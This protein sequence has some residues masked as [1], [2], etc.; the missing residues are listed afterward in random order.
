[1]L[2]SHSIQLSKNSGEKII[3]KTHG[4]TGDRYKWLLQAKYTQLRNLIYCQLK[5]DLNQEGKKIHKKQKN[6]FPLPLFP[7]FNFTHSFLTLPCP[8]WLVQMRGE[9]RLQLVYEVSPLPL[10]HPHSLLCF[11]W[12]PLNGIQFFQNWCSV[13]LHFFLDNLLLCGCLCTDCSFLWNISTCC[14]VGSSRGISVNICSNG[15]LD[16]L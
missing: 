13:D 15:V 9:L 16:G 4:V 14:S 6:T 7:S 2:L 5:I 11:M 8:L 12:N 10:L 3:W 1:M